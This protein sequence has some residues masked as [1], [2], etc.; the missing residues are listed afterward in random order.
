VQLRG[1][2]GLSEADFGHKYYVMSGL[3][4]S[5]IW[6][7]GISEASTISFEAKHFFQTPI[8]DLW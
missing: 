2:W 3:V 5:K 6:Y 4:I 7:Q 1:R 8:S